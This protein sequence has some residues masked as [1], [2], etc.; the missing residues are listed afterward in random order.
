MM[1]KS[2]LRYLSLT[3]L[4]SSLIVSTTAAAAD[5]CATNSKRKST[6]DRP[7]TIHTMRIHNRSNTTLKVSHAVK[8]FRAEPD[9]GSTLEN[10]LSS[11]HSATLSAIQGK[12]ELSDSVKTQNSGSSYDYRY[13]LKVANWDG[14]R[15]VSCSYK[16]TEGPKTS[17]YFAGDCHKLDLSPVCVDC[18]LTC[19][20]NWRVGT[21]DD[22]WSI[23][24][25]IDD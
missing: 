2:A 14:S 7:P 21:T 12:D 19:D 24:F 6:F 5:D 9:G 16:I 3:A 15:S 11:E 23:R 25:E 8:V 10:R 18:K 20:R 22:F 4:A 1:N 13:T 17:Q